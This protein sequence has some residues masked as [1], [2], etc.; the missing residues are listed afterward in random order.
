LTQ[1]IEKMEAKVDSQ[2][3]AIRTALA[4]LKR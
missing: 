3:A 4:E 1:R 2:F